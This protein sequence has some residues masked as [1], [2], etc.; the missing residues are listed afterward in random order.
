MTQQTF[1]RWKF[2]GSLPA[3]LVLH[4]DLS[5]PYGGAASPGF[6]ID[7]V[8]TDERMLMQ[9]VLYTTHD[10]VHGL[11]HYEGPTPLFLIGYK[12]SKCG[13]VFLV[14]ATVGD[15]KELVD[16]LRHWCM[17]APDNTGTYGSIERQPAPTPTPTPTPKAFDAAVDRIIERTDKHYSRKESQ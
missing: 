9:Q 17:E 3:I 15:E 1:D 14:P 11:L 16:S 7:A 8:Q 6:D 5:I 12:C 4:R 13:Q 2:A 10:R